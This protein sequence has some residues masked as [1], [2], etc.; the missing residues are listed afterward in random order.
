MK[1]RIM[2]GRNGPSVLTCTRPDGSST[3]AKV[4]DYFPTHDMT[5]YVVETTLGIPNAFYGLILQG[6]DIGDFA[7]KRASKL[8]P[9]EANLVE[10]LV[11]RLQ[12]DLMPGSDFTA[13]SFNEE[14][15]A[16]LIGIGNPSRRRID[17]TELATMRHRLRE[18]LGKWSAV[19]PGASLELDFEPR[20]TT[21]T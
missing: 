4:Q 5:H 20:T 11:G 1:I 3:W 8:F 14:V 10:A 17:D 16:V 6:W 7:V 13:E 15:E 2:K 21:H 18:L 19:E 9:P 12:R